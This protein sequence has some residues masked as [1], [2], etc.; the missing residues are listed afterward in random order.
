M[1][2]VERVVCRAGDLEPSLLN[3]GR[4]GRRRRKEGFLFLKK[5]KQKNFI[6]KVHCQEGAAKPNTLL[7]RALLLASSS[8][9]LMDKSFLLLFFKKEV[10]SC[11]DLGCI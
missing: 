5:K 4:E 6:H 8:L 1:G 3:K 10:L 11:T 2:V 7:L 9:A